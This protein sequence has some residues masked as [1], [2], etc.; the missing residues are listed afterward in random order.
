V[1][2]GLVMAVRLGCSSFFGP[3]TLPGSLGE[4]KKC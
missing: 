2:V 3:A 1:H 4:E